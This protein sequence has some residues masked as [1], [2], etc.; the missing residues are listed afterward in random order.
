MK[1]I[2]ISEFPEISIPGETIQ[3]IQVPVVNTQ[4]GRDERVGQN[5]LAQIPEAEQRP[6]EKA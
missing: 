4:A 6:G 3:P 2:G 1:I 5:W